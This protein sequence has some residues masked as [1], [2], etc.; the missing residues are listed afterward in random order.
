MDEL[1]F[2][3]SLLNRGV[4]DEVTTPRSFSVMNRDLHFVFMTATTENPVPP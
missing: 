2:R 4:I 3:R 1:P